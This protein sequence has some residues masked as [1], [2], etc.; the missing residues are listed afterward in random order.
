MKNGRYIG[1]TGCLMML[2]IVTTTVRAQVEEKVCKT[3]YNINP[4][5]VGEL[6]VELDNISF[7]KDNEYAGTVM[8]GYSLPGMWLEPKVVYYPLKNIKL[9]L[10]AHALIYSGAY[11]FPNYA[12]HDIATWKGNQYQR[13]T[14]IL[15]YFRVQL[16]LSRVNLILGNIYGGLSLIHI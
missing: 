10:G 8:K 9:E 4:E 15:P 6:S 16:A 2:L 5:R 3:D 12:Y 7:F 1:W 13:G 14:H 11:K